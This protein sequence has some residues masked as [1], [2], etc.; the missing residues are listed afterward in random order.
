MRIGWFLSSLI[1]V[2]LPASAQRLDSYSPIGTPGGT[3][4]CTTAACNFVFNRSDATLTSGQILGNLISPAM[5][6]A[7]T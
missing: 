5:T 1:L 4:A 2:A 6:P 3:I 7:E